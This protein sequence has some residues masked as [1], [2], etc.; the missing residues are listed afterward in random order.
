V[1]WR[2]R[3][4]TTGDLD[5]D[6]ARSVPGLVQSFNRQNGKIIGGGEV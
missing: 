3:D 5:R 6:P 1:N 4:E 2:I